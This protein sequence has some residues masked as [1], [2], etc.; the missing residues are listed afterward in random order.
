MPDIFNFFFN[1]IENLVP[2][3]SHMSKPG[4]AVELPV[5]QGLGEMRILHGLFN[6]AGVIK[7]CTAI[8]VV[9]DVPAEG[10]APQWRV[11]IHFQANA[12]A[13]H[14]FCQS[15]SIVGFLQTDF[16]DYLRHGG[17]SSNIPFHDMR[18]RTESH[19]RAASGLK[20]NKLN[21]NHRAV[22]L[23]W[24]PS[25]HDGKIF[26][27]QFLFEALEEIHHVILRRRFQQQ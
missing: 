7:D 26:L 15:Y 23:A 19:R 25:R 11:N 14:T 27:S 18:W 6:P 3:L 8:H 1:G 5:S 9:A 21:Y 24:S 2:A 17:V 22:C 4:N 20:S 10:S 12:V 13:S 16:V